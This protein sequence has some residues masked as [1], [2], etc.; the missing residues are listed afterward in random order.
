VITKLL[1][2]VQKFVV[3]TAHHPR[4]TS[5][6]LPVLKKQGLVA[7]R[8]E[9]LNFVHYHG[10][11]AARDFHSQTGIISVEL[12]LAV[13]ASGGVAG[14]WLLRALAAVGARGNGNFDLRLMAHGAAGTTREARFQA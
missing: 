10:R 9:H 2:V 13:T 8:T 6:A 11:R 4:K 1:V 14:A 5:S 12:A 3:H 7:N